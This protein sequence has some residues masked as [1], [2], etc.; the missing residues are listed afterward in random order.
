M[1]T[2]SRRKLDP[3]EHFC[4]SCGEVIKKAAEICPKC[5]VR[6]KEPPAVT[7][8]KKK[9][10][11]F[12]TFCLWFI[13][14]CVLIIVGVGLLASEGQEKTTSKT[15][16]IPTPTPTQEPKTTFDDNLSAAK[17][18]KVGMS[19]YEFFE[20][21]ARTP[22]GKFATIGISQEMDFKETSEGGMLLPLSD[23]RNLRLT[24][25]GVE[26]GELTPYYAYIIHPTVTAQSQPTIIF[27]EIIDASSQDAKV[28][29]VGRISC[30]LVEE[31][32]VL[33][34]HSLKRWPSRSACR[35]G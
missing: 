5:G 6:T 32:I 18:V 23:G 27:F 4:N 17:N 19:S 1:S 20:M 16:A 26:L 29:F 11:K 2:T 30:D 34:T 33:A 12:M 35:F 15:T 10:S 31:L 24:P 13:G 9:G 7:S 22:E 21:T 14:I 3:N 8:K 25:E 28:I